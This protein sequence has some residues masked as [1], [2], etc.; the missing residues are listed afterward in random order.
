MQRECERECACTKARVDNYGLSWQAIDN[1][2]SDIIFCLVAVIMAIGCHTL[3]D[4]VECQQILS[5]ALSL[6]H[7]HTHIYIYI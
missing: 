4:L 6:P 1:K 2:F 3:R 7:T 5:F